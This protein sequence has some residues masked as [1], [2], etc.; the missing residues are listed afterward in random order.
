MDSLKFSQML[1]SRLCHDLITPVGAISSGFEI[2]ETCDPEDHAELLN[3]TRQSAATAARRL[4]FYRAI[5]GYSVASQFSGFT[6]VRTLLEAFLGP[7][8]ISLRWPALDAFEANETL[9]SAVGQWGR[10]IANMTLIGAETA[11]YGGD[12]LITLT[13]GDLGVN[14]KFSG[15]LVTLR[16]ESAALF[17]KNAADDKVTP[18]TV[19]AYY[20][21]LLARQLGATL[22]LAQAGKESLEI[23]AVVGS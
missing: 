23:T 4:S 14:L 22:K 15:N 7:S 21:I 6:Q 2:M 20:T 16:P 17:Q 13:P 9:Q 5:F 3:L 11:P 1:C 19:Q 12:L 10:L 8:K 18:Q